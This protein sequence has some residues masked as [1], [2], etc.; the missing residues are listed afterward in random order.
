[1]GLVTKITKY[2]NSTVDKLQNQNLAKVAHTGMEIS[3]RIQTRLRY[4][5]MLDQ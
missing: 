2:L 3:T 5:E 1:M 4:V